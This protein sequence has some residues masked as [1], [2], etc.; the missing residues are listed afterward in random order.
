[1]ACTILYMDIITYTR[2]YRE[3]DTLAARGRQ[4]FIP[5]EYHYN[6][7]YIPIHSWKGFRSRRGRWDGENEFLKNYFWRDHWKK[8]KIVLLIK[9]VSYK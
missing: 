6:I 8:K 9:R 4:C 5:L 3:N 7:M 1:M 2:T